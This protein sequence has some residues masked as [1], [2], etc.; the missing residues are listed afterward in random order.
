MLPAIESLRCFVTAAR[1]SS[2]RA[3]ARTVGLTPAALGQRIRLLEDHYGTRLFARTTRRITLTERGLTLLPVAERCLAA[4]GECAGVLGGAGEPQ[5][6]LTIGTRHELGLSWLVPELGRLRQAHPSWEFHVYFGSGEDL[7]ARV[8]AMD[9]D[10]AITSS[11]IADDRLQTFRL[12]E[13][14]YVL[15]ASRALAKKQPLT[16]PQHAAGHRLLDI[17][18][19]LPLF[20][21]L[22]DARA[23]EGEFPFSRVIRMGT[24][25]AIR[26]RVLA[27]DGVAVLPLYLVQEDLRRGHLV[28]LLPKVQLLTDYFRLVFRADDPRQKALESLANS[29]RK[30]PLR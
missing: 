21:Y 2:F 20:S 7:L 19:S 23:T 26:Q 5:L 18:A 13:E 11:R 4:A 16:K 17:S 28:K 22:R 1:L 30:L 24:I 3:A 12:H 27:G 8:R 25:E 9:I 15:V 29:L 14:K 6:E 10:C